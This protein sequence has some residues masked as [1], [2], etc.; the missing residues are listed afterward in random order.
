MASTKTAQIMNEFVA[1]IDDSKTYSNAEI[2]K[3]LS[4]AYYKFK[5]NKD[6][7][8]GDTLGDTLG[9]A[10]DKDEDHE[11]ETAKKTPSQ[12]NRFMQIKMAEI[13]AQ[14]PEISAKERMKLAAVEWKKH[15]SQESSETVDCEISGPSDDDIKEAKP[16]KVVKK[17]PK[18]A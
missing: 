16:K 2:N 12:Y 1:N 18:A 6:Q 7:V 11:E 10:S 4:D 13:K 5:K 8:V 9:G 17:Q 14:K 3:V 15:K